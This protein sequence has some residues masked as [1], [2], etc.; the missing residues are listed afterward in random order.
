MSIQQITKLECPVCKTKY[1]IIYWESLNA[2]IDPDAKEK[3]LSGELFVKVCPSCGEANRV[4]YPL[5]YHDMAQKVMVNLVFD[6][7]G[8]EWNPKDIL[9]G[10]S[11][12]SSN[13]M[14]GYRFRVVRDQNALLEKAKI[15]DSGMDDRIIEIMKVFHWEKFNDANPTVALNDIYF[16]NHNSVYMFEF[17]ADE[18]KYYKMEFNKDMYEL[19]NNGALHEI[20]NESNDNY[21]IDRGWARSFVEKYFKP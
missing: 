19:I 11:F 6:K 3:L 16:N 18:N 17:W 21:S 4:S 13:A 15:F 8:I 2:K 1:D 14:P 10:L 9:S 20:E 5:L 7:D 12:L